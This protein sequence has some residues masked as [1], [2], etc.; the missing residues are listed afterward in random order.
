M[1]LRS[2]KLDRSTSRLPLDQRGECLAKDVVSLFDP[3]H[4]DRALQ[5]LLINGYEHFHVVSS[6]TSR[7]TNSRPA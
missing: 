7:L 2:S 4:E 3:C 6:H 1:R 5:E